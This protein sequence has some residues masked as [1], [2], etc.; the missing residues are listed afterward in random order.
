MGKKGEERK[1]KGK[2]RKEML[3]YSIVL[4]AEKQNDQHKLMNDSG[5]LAKA[6]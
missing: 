5:V 6:L 1:E 3:N 4:T 2:K